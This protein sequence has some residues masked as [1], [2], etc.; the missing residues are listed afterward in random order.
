MRVVIELNSFDKGG[1][2]KVVL[3]SALMLDR[4]IFEPVIVATGPIGHLADVARSNGLR[5][6]QI[7]GSNALQNYGHLIDE[8]KPALS[9]SHFS[10]VGYPL[11]AERAIPNITFIH[12]VYAF[13]PEAAKNKLRHDDRYVAKYISVSRKA[14][15][16]AVRNIGLPA[17]KL[18]TIPNGLLIDEHEARNRKPLALSRA[19]LG[20]AESDYVFVNVASYNLHKGHFLIADA[21]E[22]ILQERQD[23]K[24]LCVGNEVHPPHAEMLRQHLKARG[25]DKHILM[26]GYYPEVEDPM[27]IADAF[28]LPS[29]IEGWSI[30]MN[31]AMFYGK[32]MIL[33]DTGGAAEVIEDDDIGLLLATEYDDLSSLDSARLDSLAYTPQASYRLGR[34]LADAMLSF[35]AEPETLGRG[36]GDEATTRSFNAMIS[37]WSMKDTRSS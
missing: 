9:I 7:S 16:Y 18:V 31:E 22:R 15:E 34:P 12:N 28:L 23:I 1:L 6:E 5:V 26:P 21:M 25:L 10:D 27:R 8:I 36:G 32:P 14:T 33:T 29:F 24:V 11:F 19:D 20:I 2:Q 30:A 35:A 3:D 13:L 17:S 4:H 37:A